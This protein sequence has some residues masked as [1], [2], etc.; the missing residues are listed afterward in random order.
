MF[1]RIIFCFVALLAAVSAGQ[2]LHICPCCGKPLL[3]GYVLVY[4]NTAVLAE[5]VSLPPATVADELVTPAV[6]A[7]AAAPA[8]VAIPTTNG[9]KSTVYGSFAAKSG[10]A[11]EKSYKY[12]GEFEKKADKI[13]RYKLKVDGKYGKT[14]DQLTDSKAEASGELRRMLD[15]RWFAYGTLSALHDDLKDLSYRAKAGPGL[16]YY[17]VDT[18]TLVADLS[19]GPLYVQEKSSGGN[20]GYLAWRFAQWFDWSITDTFRWWVSTEADVDTADTSAFIIAFKTGV[21]SKINNNL[22][23][24]VAVKDAYDSQPEVSG[25]I[26]KNDMEISTGLRYTF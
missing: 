7:P 21:E 8:T 13:Y 3:D 24:L 23:L 2:E 15:E 6:T 10:N 14:E 9:W 22:S 18:E 26:E 5:S 1:G 11:N 16:G 20:S 4:T 25:K 17:F 19:S 12:G